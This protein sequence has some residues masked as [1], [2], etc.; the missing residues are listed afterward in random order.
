MA[1]EAEKKSKEIRIRQLETT[2]RSKHISLSV[3]A[4]EAAQVY[5]QVVSRKTP[6]YH[7]SSD[8]S[9]LEHWMNLSLDCWAERTAIRY[10]SRPMAKGHLLFV[11]AGTW[12]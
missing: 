10:P 7:P 12:V 6:A 5:L 9:A 4:I 3:E 8:R 11:P 1:L 2:F